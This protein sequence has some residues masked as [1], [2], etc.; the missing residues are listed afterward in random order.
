MKERTKNKQKGRHFGQS[1]G[2][3]TVKN[4]KNN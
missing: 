1:I 4:N 2:I 3:L